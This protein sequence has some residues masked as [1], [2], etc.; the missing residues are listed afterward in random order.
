MRASGFSLVELS[1]VLVIL[2]LLAG[3]ILAGQ[4][5]I[6]ASALTSVASD[7]HNYETAINVFKDRYNALPGDM[8]N[9]TTFWGV[10]TG[11]TT[12]FETACYSTVPA[13][14]STATCNGNGDRE[15]L[16]STTGNPSTMYGTPYS[17]WQTNQTNSGATNGSYLYGESYLAW[18]HLSNA[19]L[20]E[21]SY[22][23]VW[24]NAPRQEPGVNYPVSK[25]QSGGYGLFWADAGAYGLFGNEKQGNKLSFGNVG[26]DVARV[27]IMTPQDAYDVDL[28]LDDGLPGD[29]KVG[30]DTDDPVTCY[31]GTAPDYTYNLTYNAN[32]CSLRLALQ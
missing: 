30:I 12:G 28:K 7:L 16:A 27:A 14:G 26:K 32:V 6:R 22:T 31:T 4:S 10:R 24:D 17:T 11:S 5:L 19:G 3:G 13:T 18:Q 29:G 8:P 9:A 23:G 15:I 1:I 21:G 2:G 20:V 25:Y